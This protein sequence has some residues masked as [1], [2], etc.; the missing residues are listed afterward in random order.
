M[1]ADMEMSCDVRVLREMGG[2]AKKIT[3]IRCVVS[4]DGLPSAP[5]IK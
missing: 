3:H 2:E 4:I 5:F 1:V